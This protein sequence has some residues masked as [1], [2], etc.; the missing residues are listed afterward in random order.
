MSDNANSPASPFTHK[1]EYQYQEAGLT[2]RE[3]IAS[4]A[5]QSMLSSK[6]LSEFITDGGESISHN[7]YKGVAVEACKYADALLIQLEK[8]YMK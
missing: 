6:F 8:E 3:H 4:M 2:K 5:M 1:P 7:R